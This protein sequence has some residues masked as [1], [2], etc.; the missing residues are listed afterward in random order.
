MNNINDTIR[1]FNADREPERLRLKYAA[2]Q[3]NAFAFMRGT[4]H[5]FYQDWPAG[6]TALNDAPLAW[7]CGDLHLENFGSYKGDNGLVYFDLNDFDEAILAPATWELGRWLCSI[8]VAAQSLN[9]SQ[10]AAQQ[11]CQLGLNGYT[12]ALVAGK[13]RWLERET[14]Q[15]MIRD[16]LN[17]LKRRKRKTFLDSRTTLHKRQRALKLDGKHALPLEANEKAEVMAFIDD[18]AQHQHNPEFYRPIDAARRIAGTGSLGIDRYVIL[19]AGHGGQNGQFL[20]DLKAAAG[21]ALARHVNCPQP[22]W[23]NQAQR[24]ANVQHWVQ[25]IAPAFLSAVTFRNQAFVLKELQPSQDRLALNNWNGKFKRLAQVVCHM[26]KIVAWSHLRSGGRAG[27]AATDAWII[28]GQRRDWQDAV[29]DY[30]GK[31]ALKIQAD[32]QQFSVK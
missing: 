11:L 15:G 8:L 19:V 30:A 18:Y 28:F 21:S 12:E 9:L 17:P 24:V 22:Q 32:W 3:Q 29:L 10:E 20:L 26:G 31:Y 27:S 1:E 25:A 2:M 6:D 16:L 14:A 4:C 23:E 5:L 13:A 7:I